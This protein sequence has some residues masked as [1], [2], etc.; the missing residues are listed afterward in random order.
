M[1]KGMN[2]LA[3]HYAGRRSSSVSAAGG[4]GG[5]GD[6]TIEIHS[7]TQGHTYEAYQ[8]FSGNF[9]GGVLTDVKWGSGLKNSQ[10][11]N[12]LLDAL[13]END[14]QKDYFADCES[15]SDVAEK[16]AEQDGAFMDDS[17]L[18]DAFAETVSGCLSSTKAV[19][20]RA[21]GKRSVRLYLYDQRTG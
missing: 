13:K 1:K 2:I 18:L 20:R 3:R 10:D 12:S 19:L 21:G 17:S 7:A 15:A 5:G 16:L 11:G 8:V 6:H 4:F 9:S 14:S